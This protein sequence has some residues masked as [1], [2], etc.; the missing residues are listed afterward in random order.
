LK[1]NII[2]APFLL[3]CDE[4]FTILRDS[5]IVY[6]DEIL[7]VIPIDAAKKRFKDIG[8]IS[9]SILMPGL[10]NL[11]THLEFGSNVATLDYGSFGKW[12]NSVIKN[13][14]VLSSRCDE[15]VFQK[16]I[17]TIIKTGTT[18][19]GEISSFGDDLLPLAK[20]ELRVFFFNEAIGSNPEIIDFLFSNLELRF[21]ESKKFASKRFY[22]SIAIHSPYS[23]H[24]L[25]VKKALELC[26]GDELVSAHL[27]ESKEEREW[28]ESSSGFFLEFFERF[29][30]SKSKSNFS[31]DTFLELFEKQKTIFTHM[32]ELKK[33]EIK[34]LN[35]ELH[36]IATCPRSNRIL[37]NKLLEL[38]DF[39]NKGIK[40]ALCTDGLSSN[41]SLSLFDEMR[42][43]LF[44]YFDKDVES[45]SKELL[46]SATKN[47]GDICGKN[48]GE[49]AV[50]KKSD[51]IR[52]A[53]PDGADER[54]MANSTILNTNQVMESY[55]D[56][57]LI[58][59][60]NK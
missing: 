50:G 54:N 57:K 24:P 49:I 8:F 11:H 13:R 56:G 21:E 26:Q 1:T 19:I 43:A 42:G 9:D 10:I 6:S 40:I 12:L 33:D 2:S 58:Y 35:K 30:G 27:L 59:K 52:I 34:K 47:S 36:S 18:T 38:E 16:Q 23:T 20:S 48:I 15:D 51:F 29:F 37:N 44:G 45:L 25:L 28:L 31:L 22:P 4:D 39:A 41:Y 14:E 46:L 32:L 17:D 7:E 53:L 55:I 60:G 3:L 5:S